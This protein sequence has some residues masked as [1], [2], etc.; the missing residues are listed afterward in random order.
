[1]NWGQGSD[2]TKGD[3]ITHENVANNVSYCANP[4]TSA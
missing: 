4:Q 2:F 3:T 1:M